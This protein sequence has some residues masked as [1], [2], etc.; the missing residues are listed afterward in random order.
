M[1]RRGWVR[2]RL[3]P[4][5]TYRAAVLSDLLPD[6]QTRLQRLDF[7]W[8]SMDAYGFTPCNALSIPDELRPGIERDMRRKLALSLEAFEP[9]TVTDRV[10]RDL[11]GRCRAEGIAVAFFWAPESPKFRSWYTPGSRRAI[12]AYGRELAAELDVPVFPAPEHL[13]ETDFADGFHLLRHG[14]AKY[15]R[16]LA[17][18]HLRPWL[19]K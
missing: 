10:F 6:W 8:E 4:W 2:G 18:N 15:S 14:A 13:E 9:S 16:W 19:A 3:N 12:E 1:F 11:V 17:D 7:E 5:A